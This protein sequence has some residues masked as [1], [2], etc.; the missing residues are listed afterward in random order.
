MLLVREL[1]A[2]FGTF[3]I[4]I[5]DDTHAIIPDFPPDIVPPGLPG[6]VLL[7][8]VP[9]QVGAARVHGQASR[10]LELDLFQKAR[11]FPHA[12]HIVCLTFSKKIHSHFR[13]YD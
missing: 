7:L 13:V 6:I 1:L 5:H 12:R 10:A 11:R 4:N 8:Q 2:Y 3:G 9:L